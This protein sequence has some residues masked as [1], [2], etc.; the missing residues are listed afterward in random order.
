M[1]FAICNS[2]DLSN[3]TRSFPSTI[4]A[5]P[6]GSRYKQMF[7]VLSMGRL[8]QRVAFLLEGYDMSEF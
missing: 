2:H 5:Y 3:L 7:E 6:V 8:Y 1:K 4:Y